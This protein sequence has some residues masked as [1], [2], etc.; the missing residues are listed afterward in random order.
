VTFAAPELLLALIAV[1]LAAIGY[2]V[3]ERRRARRA[4]VWSAS[5]LLPN[6]VRR[7]RGGLSHVSVALFLLAMAFLLIGLARPQRVLGIE[8]RDPPTIVLTFDVSGSMASRDV[9]PSRIGAARNIAIEFLKE[10]PTKFRVAVMTFGNQV[11]L[12][13]PSTLDRARAISKIPA[14]VTPLSATGIGDGISHAVA[15]AVAAAGQNRR[16][17][18]SR[19]GAVL[20]FSDGEQT[21]A[22]TTPG[23]AT[24]I[25]HV[26]GVP[27]DTVA[28]GTRK[29]TVTQPIR[30]GGKEKQ[31]YP[32][33]V[34]RTALRMIA[35]GSGG[36]AFDGISV[37]Q[38]PTPLSSVYAGLNSYS[39][40]GRRSSELSAAVTAVALIL[41]LAGIVVSGLWFGRVA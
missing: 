33:P 24:V 32:V 31:T 10:L 6:I 39:T 14:A 40:A 16:G 37:A 20:L 13:V 36:T 26:N 21:A 7:P 11:R 25:A 12:V 1:P 41:L 18:L 9:S 34:Q 17:A 23:D 29:G 4:A 8:T 15:E 5:A 35:K 28:M 3:L 2:G 38:S 19:P 22:G 27:V 30:I